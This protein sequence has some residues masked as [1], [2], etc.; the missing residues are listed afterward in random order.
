MRKIA[1][2]R[3]RERK[4]SGARIKEREDEELRKSSEQ[5]VSVFVCV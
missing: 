1:S 5:C 3:E 4:E 2:E